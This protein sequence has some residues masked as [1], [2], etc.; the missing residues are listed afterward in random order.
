[1]TPWRNGSASDSSSEGCVFE[2]RRGHTF[3][4]IGMYQNMVFD[5]AN[6]VTRVLDLIFHLIID[7]LTRK[8]YIKLLI[9][10]C[11]VPTFLT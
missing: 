8:F 5:F 3:L 9:N 11:M 6:N 1:M 7:V 4:S 10:Q 2:S